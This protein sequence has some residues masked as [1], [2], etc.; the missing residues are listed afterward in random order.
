MSEQKRFNEILA[1]MRAGMTTADD[2]E[3]LKAMMHAAW[4]RNAEN[5]RPSNV[6][7]LPTKPSEDAER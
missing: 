5:A 2:A 7:P 6:V 1:R 3:R 4:A